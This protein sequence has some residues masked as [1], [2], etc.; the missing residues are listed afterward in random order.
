MENVYTKLKKLLSDH[1]EKKGFYF[2]SVSKLDAS[3]DFAA[4]GI[5][6]LSAAME[7]DLGT[8]EAEGLGAKISNEDIYKMITNK[9][10]KII[11]E[12]GHLPWQT[13]INNTTEAPFSFADLP[14]NYQSGKYYS[15]INA[16]VLSMYRYHTDETRGKIHINSNGE[17]EEGITEPI[18]DDRLFWLTFKQIKEAN[19][20]L[21]KGSLSQQAV[22]YNFIYTYEGKKITEKRYNQLKKQLGCEKNSSP[23]CANLRRIGFLKYYN[24]F[25]ERDIENIDF[26]AKRAELKEKSKSIKTSEK[27]ILAADLVLKHM[28]NKPKFET[29]FLDLD[30]GSSPHYNPNTDTVVMPLKSQ[31][32]NVENWY[33]IAFHELIHATGHEKRTNRRNLKGFER[34]EKW[35]DS[36]YALEELVAEIG[37]IF[38]NAESGIMLANLK[39]NAAYIKG[40]SKSVKKELQDNH[41]AIFKAAAQS[42]KAADYILNRDKNGDPAYWK[43]FDKIS[44]EIKAKGKAQKGNKKQLIESLIS[45]EKL[46]DKQIEQIFKEYAADILWSKEINDYVKEVHNEKINRSKKEEKQENNYPFS[47]D[48]I[49]Y[50]TGRRAHLNTSF[51]PEKRAKQ[52]QKYYFNDLKQ[53][54][55]KYH[56]EAVKKGLEDKFNNL[57]SKFQAGFLKRRISELQSRSRIAS[58]MITGGSGFNVRRNEKANNVHKSKLKETAHY[59]EKYQKY[60]DDLI[61]PSQKP[62]KTGKKGSLEKLEEKLKTLEEKHALMKKG[63]AK[64]RQLQKKGLTPLELITEYEKYL[65]EIGFSKKEVESIVNLSKREEKLMYLPFHL[66]NSNA[67]IRTV[68]ERIKM[69]KRLKEQAKKADETGETKEIKFKG[70]VIIN[71][72]SDN[73]VKIDFDEKPS[74]EI[75]NFL[76]K[77][78]HRFKW[79]P[80]NKVWQRQLNTYYSLNRKELYEFLD[81]ETPTPEPPKPT[82]KQ[83]EPKQDE[84]GQLALF[85][86]KGKSNDSLFNKQILKAAQKGY[87]LETIFNLGNPKH[88]LKKHIEDFEITMNGYVLSK[89]MKQT[90][91]HCLNWGNFI[92]LPEYLNKPHAIFKSK[93]KGYVVL[94][95]IKD[96]NK[97]P[98]MVALHI[99]KNKQSTRIASLYTRNSFD[100]YKKW[101]DEKL[102]LF[103]DRKSELF[104][105]ATATIAVTENNS[106]SKITTKSGQN[107]NRSAIKYDKA[108]MEQLKADHNVSFDFIRKSINGIRKSTTALLIKKEYNELVNGSKNGLNG[109]NDPEIIKEVPQAPTQTIEVKKPEP[110]AN[111]LVSKINHESTVNEFFEIGGDI[112]EFLG[113]IE[114]KPVGSVACTIDAE[115][116]AGKTRFTFQ[117]ANELAKKYKVLFISLEEHPQSALF[118]DKVKQYIEPKNMNNIDA[119]GDLDRGKE[120]QLLDSLIPNY[121]VIII[122]SWNKIFEASKLDF[123]NDLRKAYNGKLIFAIF[124]RTVTGGMRGGTKAGFDG[125][126]IMKGIKGDDFKENVIIHNKNRYQSKNLTKLRYNVYHQELEKTEAKTEPI[127]QDEAPVKNDFLEW[128][129]AIITIE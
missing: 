119:I 38:L 89:A 92:D 49:P 76:K 61:F 82:K 42:Q 12:S 113:D 67:K 7:N 110:V 117:I 10:I 29:L 16:L 30:K 102:L 86:L 52:E 43:E 11:D 27:R 35:G 73:R 94:T 20:K 78:G 33:G 93:T 23:E 105:Y 36:Q 19:G 111:P 3:Q 22:Y 64:I 26:E 103:V 45:P 21:K 66:Q 28:P 44:E 127:K 39:N 104:S 47:L 114:I 65:V 4:L 68:K 122:D 6:Y 118:Q 125:D 31:F 50:E 83:P 85:G 14:M 74:L 96:I 120:K 128:D 48:D 57:F 100:S 24:V 56:S 84:K 25:N 88:E 59:Y 40:W 5:P 55:D 106:Q 126:I 75:R 72:F 90:K 15:G 91:D 109:S 98:I 112:G 108:A 32:D 70:G 80:Y 2:N 34:G 79:S 99:H 69:E 77:S 37:A 62:I 18:T 13:G 71:D 17:L 60:F 46:T 9:F 58:T 101:I 87:K 41:K 81:V 8:T 123:D 51:Y 107:K 97:K 53:I 95:E 129:D 63:N 115:Q 124:Q 54:F 121:D 116:G 1:P